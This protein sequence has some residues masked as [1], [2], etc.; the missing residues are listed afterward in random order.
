MALT[1]ALGLVGHLCAVFNGGRE[2]K[3]AD[4]LSA[5]LWRRPAGEAECFANGALLLS[6]KEAAPSFSAECGGDDLKSVLEAPCPWP[7][8][9]G[10]SFAVLYGVQVR[11][12]WRSR[13]HLLIEAGSAVT[14]HLL[15]GFVFF[16]LSTSPSDI[17]DIQGY[18][19]LV[20][21]Y[22]MFS[23]SMPTVVRLYLALHRFQPLMAGPRRI[24]RPAPLVLAQFCALLLPAKLPVYIVS[25]IAMYYI[26]GMTASP[27]YHILIF[28]ATL[29]LL[30]ASGAAMG[31]MAAALAGSLERAQVA[32]PLAGIVALVM[33]NLTTVPD[34]T[35]ILRWIQYLSPIFWSYQ[36]LIR[37]ELGGVASAGILEMY[38]MP[39]A[40]SLGAL[41][42]LTVSFLAV[43]L[44][45][46]A[47]HQH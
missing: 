36:C 30:A 15:I 46:V 34:A 6:F 18:L 5:L 28:E 13:W 22:Y 14:S 9:C 21:V 40:A 31:L 39:T 7:P 8:P 44:S 43:A 45:V 35:W 4:R 16:Q 29:I 23:F 37:N 19:F 33:G 1:A 12:D 2:D 11:E 3:V 32:V 26:S 24:V 20:S 17:S 42:L 41:A 25:S 47:L 38:T 10:R 27:F